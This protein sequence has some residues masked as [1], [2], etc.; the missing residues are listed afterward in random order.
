VPNEPD[1]GRVIGSTGLENF[2]RSS[3]AVGLQPRNH[4]N[5]LHFLAEFSHLFND[6]HRP[7]VGLVAA[8]PDHPERLGAE[9]GVVSH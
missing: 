9:V 4:N 8:H 7:L 2:S 6:Q 3:L 5:P 1:V